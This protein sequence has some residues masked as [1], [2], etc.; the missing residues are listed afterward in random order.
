MALI[1]DAL[2]LKK[3]KTAYDDLLVKLF[4]NSL[5]YTKVQRNGYS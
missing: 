4:E 5:R 3:D 1:L 2:Q